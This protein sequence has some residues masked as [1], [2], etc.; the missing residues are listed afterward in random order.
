MILYKN[1][2]IRKHQIF[3]YSRWPG[4]LFGSPSMAGTRPGGKFI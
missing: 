3:A 2:E 4:G 1:E